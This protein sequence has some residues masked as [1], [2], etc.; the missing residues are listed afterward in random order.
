[1]R[2]GHDRVT[3]LDVWQMNAVARDVLSKGATHS[4][5]GMIRCL[6]AFYVN[7]ATS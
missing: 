6:D 4:A 5:R 3:M 1:M 2:I 7:Y